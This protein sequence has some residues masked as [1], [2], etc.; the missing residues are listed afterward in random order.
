MGMKE[1][2]KMQHL[3]E[4]LYETRVAA[5]ERLISSFVL[6]HRMVKPI[7]KVPFLGF[8]MDR[9]ESRL[10]VASTP[11]PVAMRGIPDFEDTDSTPGI[12]PL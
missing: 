9:T 2:I 12:L 7:S 6:F 3:C 10:R 4:T 11:A 1:T 5:A 8:D